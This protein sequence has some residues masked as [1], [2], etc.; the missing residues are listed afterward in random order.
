MKNGGKNHDDLH[1]LKRVCFVHKKNSKSLEK[2]SA[3]HYPM[4]KENGGK[5]K[6]RAS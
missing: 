3:L 2:Q 6:K 4:K 5:R 1:A